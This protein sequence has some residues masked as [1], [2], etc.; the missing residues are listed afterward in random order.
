MPQIPVPSSQKR[1][2][3]QSRRLGKLRVIISGP[4]LIAYSLNGELTCQQ[5]I[6]VESPLPDVRQV[7]DVVLHMRELQR[8][9]DVVVLY[10]NS[11]A[12]YQDLC[13]Q[14]IS[15]LEQHQQACLVLLDPIFPDEVGSIKRAGA[16]GYF[17]TTESLLNFTT[18]IRHIASGKDKTYFPPLPQRPTVDSEPAVLSAQRRLIFRRT[19]LDACAR[20]INWE[21][22]EKDIYL[23][24]HFGY[25]TE[26]LAAKMN[27]Q[28]ERVRHDLSQRVYQF[29]GLLARKTVNS[30][31]LA[32]Q[33]LLEYGIFE[34]VPSSEE[35]ME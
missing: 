11:N 34:Y 23:I 4:E 30:R 18:A 26:E 33:V 20:A 15:E 7:V 3:R 22:T 5:D 28:A 12:T 29:L 27:R 10:W 19:R 1:S 21:L 2:T 16:R 17:F 32:F 35:E 13:L 24:R 14:T 6:E 8:P 25:G 31:F 9:V